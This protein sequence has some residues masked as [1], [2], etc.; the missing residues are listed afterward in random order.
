MEPECE[1]APCRFQG[2]AIMALDECG[3]WRALLW[4]AARLLLMGHKYCAQEGLRVQSLLCNCTQSLGPISVSVVIWAVTNLHKFLSCLKSW[5]ENRLQSQMGKT[6]HASSP[7]V[8]LT[9]LSCSCS[10]RK[11]LSQQTCRHPSSAPL[12]LLGMKHLK[13]CVTPKINPHSFKRSQWWSPAQPQ[14][15]QRALLFPL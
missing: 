4:K 2:A 10:K 9:Q 7:P 15:W 1:G 14:P 11:L 12:L 13:A 8:A 6:S 5:Q 3:H